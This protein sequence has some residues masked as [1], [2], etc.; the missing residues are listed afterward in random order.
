MKELAELLQVSGP[1][2]TL[3]VDRLVEMGLLM[4]S[5]NPKDRRVVELRMSKQGEAAMREHHRHMET[6]ILALMGRLGPECT[7]QWLDVYGRI[8][9]VLDDELRAEI[10]R[11][12]KDEAKS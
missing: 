12:C 10:L 9:E 3:M 2:A 11:E 7:E 1:S 6:I 8:R 5:Q 4:R